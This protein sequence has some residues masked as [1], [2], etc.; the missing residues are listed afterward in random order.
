LLFAGFAEAR[1]AK[2]IWA[3]KTANRKNRLKEIF[4]IMER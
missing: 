2:K 1:F 4:F 3:I